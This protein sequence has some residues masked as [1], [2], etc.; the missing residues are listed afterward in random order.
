ML[1]LL[2][3]AVV[4]SAAVPASAQVPARRGAS[5]V[6]LV[7]GGVA[8]NGPA[9]RVVVGSEFPV[10]AR[11]A[12]GLV[13]RLAGSHGAYASHI[14]PD[15]TAADTYA[16]F[17]LSLRPAWRVTDRLE[18]AGS[19]GYGLVVLSSPSEGGLDLGYRDIG[20]TVPLEAEVTA[21]VSRLVGVS[22]AASRSVALSSYRNDPSTAVAPYG[23][24]YALDQW[25]TTVGLRIGR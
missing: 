19:A 11:G 24:G 3:L 21:R 18:V 16:E 12:V 25:T 17:G 14:R 10:G 20:F 23:D 15:A 5:R 4:L 7:G 13:A 9:A 8:S 2:C 1:R 22:V 6:L